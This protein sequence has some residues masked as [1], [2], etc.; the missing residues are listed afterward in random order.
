MALLFWLACHHR[1]AEPTHVAVALP[2]FPILGDCP[3]EQAEFAATSLAMAIEVG[4]PL[5]NEGDHAGC[6]RMYLGTATDVDGRL[7]ACAGVRARLE[8]AI[9]DA[10]AQDTY[11]DQA[12][13]MRHAFDDVLGA[14]SR[15]TAK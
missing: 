9:N 10:S 1:P 6:Y 15:T 5:Y 12:W 8:A 7:T 4:A 13:T 2:G 3:K 11:T 14:W